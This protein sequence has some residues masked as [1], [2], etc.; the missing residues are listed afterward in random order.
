MLQKRC[1]TYIGLRFDSPEMEEIM[2][3]QEK[4]AW[5]CYYRNKI[6]TIDKV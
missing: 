5:C 2:A 1:I 4:A 3:T 6:I